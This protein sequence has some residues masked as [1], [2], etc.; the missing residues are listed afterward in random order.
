MRV[1]LGSFFFVR[2]RK[3]GTRTLTNYHT[4]RVQVP[5]HHTLTQNLYQK[6]YYPNH[7]HLI[8]GYM[9]LLGVET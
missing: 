9:D 5:N 1:V 6:D 8:I 7:E 4:L 2:V 3:M